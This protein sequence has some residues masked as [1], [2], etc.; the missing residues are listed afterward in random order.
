MFPLA[1]ESH[2]SV[3]GALAVGVGWLGRT[4]FV[5]VKGR[6]QAESFNLHQLWQQVQRLEGE[7]KDLR[8]AL[9][10]SREERA[11]LTQENA[12]LEREVEQMEREI[13]TLTEQNRGQQREIETLK[14]EVLTLKTRRP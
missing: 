14:S 4:A 8:D 1:E 11:K 6:K 9:Q 10:V 3:I 13:E 12:N 5:A 2:W 7:V